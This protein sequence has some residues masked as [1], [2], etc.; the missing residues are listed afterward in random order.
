L[1]VQTLKRENGDV[2]NGPWTAYQSKGCTYCVMH[3]DVVLTKSNGQIYD[4]K[5]E[6][7]TCTH[8]ESRDRPRASIYLHSTPTLRYQESSRPVALSTG[9]SPFPKSSTAISPSS[10]R[11]TIPGGEP[12]LSSQISP[13]SPSKFIYPEKNLPRSVST[14]SVQSRTSSSSIDVGLYQK[15][16]Q[17]LLQQQ[18]KQLPPEAI[19]V[20][21]GVSF[22]HHRASSN[23]TNLPPGRIPSAPVSPLRQSSSLESK[24]TTNGEKSPASTTRTSRPAS[25]PTPHHNGSNIAVPSLQTSKLSADPSANK[26][27]VE[28]VYVSKKK[29]MVKKKKLQKDLLLFGLGLQ[30]SLLELQVFYVLLQINIHGIQ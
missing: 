24:S 20:S 9:D 13:T 6:N 11:V 22:G 14:S 27:S 23:Q 16:Q 12:K 3:G 29:S 28:G 30:I 18:Q 25:M 26:P 8:I 15:Q 5:W 2:Y 1:S 7:G 19:I 17:Q 4:T 21:K 10:L